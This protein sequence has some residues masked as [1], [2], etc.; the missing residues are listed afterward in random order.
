MR[1][2]GVTYLCRTGALWILCAHV[3]PLVLL[4]CMCVYVCMCVHSCVCGCMYVCVCVCVCL[5][6][7]VTRLSHPDTESLGFLCSHSLT[8]SPHTTAGKHD[9]S[10][11]AG[12]VP[13]PSPHCSAG[14]GCFRDKQAF[15]LS[16]RRSGGGWGWPHGEQQS[17]TAS[18]G[19]L[20]AESLT[21]VSPQKG[22]QPPLATR[23]SCLHHHWPDKKSQRPLLP[24]VQ[25]LQGVRGF[26][27]L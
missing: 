25:S 26:W 2:L 6:L 24:A 4:M 5:D 20:L 16:V 10:L 27:H 23:L 3:C 11:G 12:M 7:D 14:T 9:K 17:A 1:V 19:G 22:T 18:S 21:F 8:L 13:F 15:F